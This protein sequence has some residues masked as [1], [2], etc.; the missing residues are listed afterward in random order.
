MQT[1]QLGSPPAVDMLFVVLF[2]RAEWGEGQGPQFVKFRVLI[3]GL[4]RSRV[5][6][7]V[8]CSRSECSGRMQNVGHHLLALPARFTP[9]VVILVV[10]CRTPEAETPKLSPVSSQCSP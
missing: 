9:R 4:G 1:L 3:L 7:L 2:G 8:A 5:Y 10:P 6:V